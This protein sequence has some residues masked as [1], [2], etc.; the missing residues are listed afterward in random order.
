[1]GY[2]WRIKIAHKQIRRNM[3]GTQPKVPIAVAK[4]NATAS[5]IRK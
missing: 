5:K 2:F 3:R 1:L 4:I